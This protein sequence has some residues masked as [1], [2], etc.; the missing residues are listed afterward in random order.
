MHTSMYR[1][2]CVTFEIR[3]MGLSLYL[4]TP[5]LLL[6]FFLCPLS[7]LFTMIWK[8]QLSQCSLSIQVNEVEHHAL[9][10]LPLNTMLT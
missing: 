8:G 6:S 10:N 9:V 1:I 4:T 2:D 3:F 7:I 5:S